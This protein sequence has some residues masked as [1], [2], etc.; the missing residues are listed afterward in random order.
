MSKKWMIL[1]LVL[2][3]TLVAGAANAA[4]A[5]QGEGAFLAGLFAEEAGVCKAGP[6]ANVPAAV[7]LLYDVGLPELEACYPPE[8]GS[9]APPGCPNLTGCCRYKCC[10]C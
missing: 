3:S 8:C 2:L 7:K 9:G 10:V 6:A 4:E 5:P 1:C